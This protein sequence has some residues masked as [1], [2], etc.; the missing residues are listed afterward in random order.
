MTILK[1]NYNK[2]HNRNMHNIMMKRDGRYLTIVIDLEEAETRP[3][4]TGKS[5]IIASTGG[6]KKV[7]ARPDIF[8][9]VTCFKKLKDK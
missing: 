9:G 4:S 3:S 7:Q 2:L 6:N 5:E 1:E 8:V